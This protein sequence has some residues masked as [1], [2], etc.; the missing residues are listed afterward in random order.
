MKKIINTLFIKP[1]TG[2]KR[3]LI[4][5]ILTIISVAVLFTSITIPAS[6]RA[7]EEVQIM[8]EAKMVSETLAY[9][10]A[11]NNIP[12]IIKLKKS[13]ETSTPNQFLQES[14]VNIAKQTNS[15]TISI[16]HQ[17]DGKFYQLMNSH[18]DIIPNSP[19]EGS[20]EVGEKSLD[21]LMTKTVSPTNH[22]YRYAKTDYTASY[23]PIIDGSGEF[24]AIV[25]VEKIITG[26]DYNSFGIISW[27]FLR[28]ISILATIYCGVALYFVFNRVKD[29]FIVKKSLTDNIP[30]AIEE[31][32]T[33][34]EDL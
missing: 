30:T 29:R 27:P 25:A 20:L 14:L 11:S 23:S 9:S 31:T 22:R 26:G 24:T 28:N 1:F 15:H 16:L 7:A 8:E 21:L 6:S 4:L 3:T 18:D 12:D 17:V 13:T 33:T 34:E 5:A 10:L 19:I 2:L 32:P